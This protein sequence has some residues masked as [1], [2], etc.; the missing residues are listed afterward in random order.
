MNTQRWTKNLSGKSLCSDGFSRPP[1]LKSLLRGVFRI[2]IKRFALTMTLVLMLAVLAV[3]QAVYA[4]SGSGDGT[5]TASGD[6][7]AGLRGSGTVTIS[8]SGVLMIRDSGGD[9]QIDIS[10]SGRRT[11]LPSGWIRYSGFNGA[12]TV[13][14]SKI[15]VALSGINIEM[16]ASGTGKFVLRGSGSYSLEK[17]GVTRTGVWSE[18]VEVRQLR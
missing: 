7:L 18:Q 14:G 11:E 13:S 12:A 6:G 16:Q 1:R 17:D 4:Q 3:P 5:L 15:T 10:G 9:A 8:G 2:D